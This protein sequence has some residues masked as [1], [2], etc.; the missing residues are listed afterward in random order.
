MSA[1]VKAEHLTSITA[2]QINDINFDELVF[3][4]LLI[5]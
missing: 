1:D 2:Q 4:L 3:S 5:E